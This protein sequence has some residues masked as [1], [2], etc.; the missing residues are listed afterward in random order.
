MFAF[1]DTVFCVNFQVIFAA[2]VAR[3][4]LAFAS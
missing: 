1:D 3:Q 4:Q 2:V